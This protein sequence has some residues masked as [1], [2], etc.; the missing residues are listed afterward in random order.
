VICSMAVC[1]RNKK[2]HLVWV[3]TKQGVYIVRSAYHM[4]KE[5]GRREGGSCFNA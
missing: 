1:P 2:D 5:N 3:G 4:V